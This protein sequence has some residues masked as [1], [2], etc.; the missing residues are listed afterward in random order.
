MIKRNILIYFNLT[1]S[2][3]LSCI[4]SLMTSLIALLITALSKYD[5]VNSETVC[6][7]T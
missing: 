5:S 7:D 1:T 4:S 6:L 3:A 2:G